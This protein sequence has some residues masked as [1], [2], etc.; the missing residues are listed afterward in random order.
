MIYLLNFILRVS[1][2]TSQDSF[3]PGINLIPVNGGK[4]WYK[5]IT[6]NLNCMDLQKYLARFHEIVIDINIDGLPILAYFR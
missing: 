6:F 4:L 2:L 3:T 5:G 1:K